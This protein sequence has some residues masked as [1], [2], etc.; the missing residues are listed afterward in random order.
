MPRGDEGGWICEVKWRNSNCR[1]ETSSAALLCPLSSVLARAY[2][3]IHI[4]KKKT[5]PRLIAEDM[6][7]FGDAERVKVAL[8]VNGK[9]GGQV[10]M[11][12]DF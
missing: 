8:Y 4:S 6:R 11:E 10:N 5:V 7:I 2:Y 12:L 9:R 1:R 3:N